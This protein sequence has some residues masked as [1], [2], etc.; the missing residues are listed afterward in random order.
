MPGRGLPAVDELRRQVP[1]DL[2]DQ[3]VAA[4]AAWNRLPASRVETARTVAAHG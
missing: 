1:L 4:T 2:P 3:E